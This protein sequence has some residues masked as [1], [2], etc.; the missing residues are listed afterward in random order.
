MKMKS[1]VFECKDISICAFLY[2][3]GL[4]K[5][6]GKR[7]LQ[8]GEVF[9]QFSTKDKADE[10]VKLYWNLQAP[11]IQPKQLFSARRDVQDLIF[12]P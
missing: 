8:N 12:S 1:D 7:K 4:V 2:A 5:L 10:L 9:L 6:V 11:F 3:T